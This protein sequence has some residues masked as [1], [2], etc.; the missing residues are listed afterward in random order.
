MRLESTAVWICDEPAIASLRGGSKSAL[1]DDH[2]GLGSRLGDRS[3]GGP[4]GEEMPRRVVGDAVIGDGG[5]VW[6]DGHM[7]SRRE[8]TGTL[9]SETE[10]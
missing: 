6:W 5:A 8:A 9:T 4:I 7:T 10:G 1:T 3:S 2:E